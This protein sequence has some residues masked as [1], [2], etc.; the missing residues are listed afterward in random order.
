MFGATYFI[1]YAWMVP[2]FPFFAFILI[3][4]FTIRN[5]NLS[6]F[7]SI[8]AIIL[9]T[10]YASAILY[11][12]LLNIHAPAVIREITWLSAGTVDLPIG[13][14]V[15]NLSAAMLCLV[16]FIAFLIQ[17]Y[18]TSYM[19]NEEETGFCRY[20][21]FMSL[22]AASML[23]L[24]ISPNFF[25][26][27]IF[28]EL[29][30]LCSYLLI[31]FWYNRPSAAQAAKKA[32]IVTRFGDLG[33]LIGI[34]MLYMMTKS[35]S[36]NA[37]PALIESYRVNPCI[38][39]SIM[40]G[41]YLTPEFTINL[42][43]FF[44]FCGA[45]GKS[46][47]FPLHVWLPDAM[48]GPTP[49]SALIHAATMVA[50]GVYMV[51]QTYDIFRTAPQ[52]LV[53]IAY[54]GGITAFMAATMAVAQNDIKRVLAYSTVSQLGTMMLALGMGALVAG[55]FHL[56]THAF[57]KALLFLCAGSV[58]HALHTNNIWEMGNL[59]H[60]MKITGVT[61]LIGALAIAGIPPFSGFWSKDEIIA[62]VFASPHLLL[63]IMGCL[64]VFLTAFY[65]FRV[66]F[67]AFVSKDRYDLTPHEY[68]AMT[69]PLIILAVFSTFGGFVGTPWNNWF[70]AFLSPETV[71]ESGA[72]F[73]ILPAAI[74]LLISLF[75]IGMAYSLYAKEPARYEELL[76]ERYKT[77]Y[78]ILN[79]KYWI[80]DFWNAV[81][82]VVIASLS[83][84]ANFIDRKII[85]G[86]LVDGSARLADE[87]G[88]YLRFEES[89]SVQHYAVIIVI[90]MVIIM[91]AVGIIHGHFATELLIKSGAW[92]R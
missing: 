62:A 31:G 72:G 74:S 83:R 30:G 85:N 52:T 42:V 81:V 27:Y 43:M 35:F 4:L 56:M 59:R 53:I 65:M 51:A 39:W 9:S 25:Q 80:D 7:I 20:F 14:L 15:N 68:P 47:M 34:I 60:S 41:Q 58:I 23:G 22:F 44:I 3:S 77:I 10:I 18:S 66:Y 50:A 54:I 13:V 40:P 75:A 71:H 61:F 86:L 45:I 79:N 21:A 49:V 1:D 78:S 82:R 8:T 2:F 28:W 88:K 38:L 5:R 90:S 87:A 33:F 73:S 64:V 91:L 12:R 17:I 89:G 55:T 46:A 36:F 69:I 76:R 26:I 24:V 67:V 37:I 63:K 32:F 84:A 70:A 6:A 29:V 11:N 48:E 19:E 16:S 92:M 57:F